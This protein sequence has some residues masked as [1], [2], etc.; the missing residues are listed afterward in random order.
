MQL[1]IN[2]TYNVTEIQNYIPHTGNGAGCPVNG[3]IY[4]VNN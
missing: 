4:G 3:W 2:K 1:E